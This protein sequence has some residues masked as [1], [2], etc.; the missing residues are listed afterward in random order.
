MTPDQVHCLGNTCGEPDTAT[1]LLV[2]FRLSLGA[3][4][5]AVGLW[6]VLRG[7]Y[8][9]WGCGC[10][11][12]GAL[13]TY[14]CMPLRSKQA[15]MVAKTL[16]SD[17]ALALARKLL[18][19][20]IG[21]RREKCNLS[22]VHW[23]ENGGETRGEP[24]ITRKSQGKITKHTGSGGRKL[25]GGLENWGLQRKRD[26]YRVRGFL[27]C[28]PLKHVSLHSHLLSCAV[29]WTLSP[30]LYTFHSFCQA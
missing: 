22:A 19:S 29:E 25:R 23:R 6:S 15:S 20:S 3:A 9:L 8:C 21:R 1:L 5:A 18:G 14:V 4:V 30:L 17:I 13:V 16:A 7:G 24:G 28:F 2:H 27:R 11:A 26:G 12:Y 10:G